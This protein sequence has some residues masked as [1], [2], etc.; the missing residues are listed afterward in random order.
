[1]TAV[2]LLNGKSDPGFC[3]QGSEWWMGSV[4]NKLPGGGKKSHTGVGNFHQ[5][6]CKPV[7]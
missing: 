2:V 5:K 7:Q 6:T 4:G 3:E 1:M